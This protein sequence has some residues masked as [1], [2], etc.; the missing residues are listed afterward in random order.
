MF[1]RYSLQTR[2]LVAI[3][4]TG[5][6]T[7]AATVGVVSW[8]AVGLAK[9]QATDSAHAVAARYAAMVRNDIEPAL[10]AA[11]TLAL[12][13]TGQLDAGVVP[14]REV[15]DQQ[16]RAVVAGNQSFYGVWTGW[17]A[18][19][20]D[21]RDSS[22]AGQPGYDAT[23]R[24]LPYYY[25]GAG[26]I[27]RD[28]LVGYDVPGDG[29]YYLL[30][31][32]SGHETVLNPYPYT[33]DGRQILM[34]SLAV[35]VQHGGHVVGVTGVD[36]TL[37]ML[38]DLIKDIRIGKS[39]YL[40]VLAANQTIAAHVDAE[41]AGKAYGEFEP[42]S[43]THVD[44]M[45]SPT[46]FTITARDQASGDTY[47]HIV[48][49]IKF[50]AAD[51]TW[52]VVVSLPEREVLAEAHRIAAMAVIVGLV[53]VVVLAIVVFAIARGI[54]RP[55]GSISLDLRSGAEQVRNAS[56]Q[57]AQAGQQLAAGAG[58]QAA[59]LQQI[60][61]SLHEITAMTQRNADGAG[62]AGT[63]MDDV[64]KRVQQ[65]NTDMAA[66]TGAI[67]EIRDSAA[68]TSRI[69]KTIDE[70]AFQTNLLALNAA[71]EA[72]RAGEAGKG[73]A[74]VAE[75]VR[76]LAKRSAEAARNTDA[77]IERSQ[78]SSRE[79]VQFTERVVAS[80]QSIAEQVDRA[81][82][83][84]QAMAQANSEQ[85]AGIKQISSAVTQVDQTT[86]N[87]AA[88]AEESASAAEEMSAQAEE[89]NQ[90]VM[91][92]ETIVRGEAAAVV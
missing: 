70:I 24:Y 14:S 40:T 23:G 21:Q 32:K 90:A 26:G 45:A 20:Y 9:K 15:S 34:T 88:S 92:L 33:I 91:T 8:L 42:W 25:R 53:G 86:Q 62:E 27:A 47:L 66:M 55:V 63:L 28:V 73:F 38:H 5:L 65:G 4:G 64:R 29:D 17:E 12:S 30:S 81:A 18:G 74:V 49:P 89:L 67:G 52:M 72:A 10:A 50:G 1:R 79:G 31:F 46:G 41:R 58:Q 6:L 37:D 43:T 75:E 11:R 2:M 56:G 16:L 51:Q 69:L 68:E 85:A 7:I 59:A 13:Q 48:S 60:A 76:N 77:L 61:S 83:V 54:S 35:P 82:N 3:C 22:Y 19:A 84:V 39:G 80:F 78:A 71:V 87:N 57:V 36:V 44:E